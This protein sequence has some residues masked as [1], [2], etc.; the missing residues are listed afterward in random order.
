MILVFASSWKHLRALTSMFRR[1][2]LTVSSSENRPLTMMIL[3]TGSAARSFSDRKR[4][5]SALFSS[6]A[7]TED[8][9]LGRGSVPSSITLRMGA[10]P[11]E[12]FCLVALLYLSNATSIRHSP[13]HRVQGEL[14]K[15]Y[16]RDRGMC[17]T[18]MVF[19]D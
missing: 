16:L 18:L 6:R 8:H 12:C 19:P 4:A 17:Y 10:W 15:I 3:L 7:S 11:R 2:H 5:I 14:S 9:D 13:F 1:E